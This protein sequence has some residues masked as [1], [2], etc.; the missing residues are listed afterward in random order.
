M[1]EVRRALFTAPSPASTLVGVVVALRPSPDAFVGWAGMAVLA[2]GLLVGA[3]AVLDALARGE[4]WAF[5]G[6]GLDRL[7]GRLRSPAEIFD[8]L[9]PI[10]D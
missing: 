1:G 9:R 5:L 2:A 7:D 6:C 3:M 10:Y 8:V 4:S